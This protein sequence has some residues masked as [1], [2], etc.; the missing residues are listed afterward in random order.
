MGRSRYK[1]FEQEQP[2]F[3]TSTVINWLPL[4]AAPGIVDFI[5]AS[6]KFMREQQR[7]FIYGYVIMENHLHFIVSSP[8]NLSKEGGIFRDL[9]ARERVRT[10][11]LRWTRKRHGCILT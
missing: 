8:T 5:Y 11:V 7:L 3:F 1:I 6:W 2:R 4:F 9:I 10:Y